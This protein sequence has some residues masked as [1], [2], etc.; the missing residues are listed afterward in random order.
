MAMARRA[1]MTATA[2]R[3]MGQRDTT[4]GGT[5]G[6]EVDDYGEGA[7]GDDDYEW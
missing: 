1:T 4:G 5:A 2:Q 7:K 6:Y 3:A